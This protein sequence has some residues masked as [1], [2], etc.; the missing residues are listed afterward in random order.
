[1]DKEFFYYKD[2][3]GELAGINE[4]KDKFATKAQEKG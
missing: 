1:M 3:K 4:K 2:L